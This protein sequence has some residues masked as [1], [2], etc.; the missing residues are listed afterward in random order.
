MSTP[1]QRPCLRILDEPIEILGLEPE[2]WMIL[3]VTGAVSFVV[4]GIAAIGLIVAGFLLLRALKR[5][6]PS[7][8][9]FYLAYRA[10][11]TRLLPRALRPAGLLDRGWPWQRPFQVKYSANLHAPAKDRFWKSDLFIESETNP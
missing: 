2:D 6:K 10:G 7:G 5:G 3:M 4:N 1:F 11:W 8:Y 9:L